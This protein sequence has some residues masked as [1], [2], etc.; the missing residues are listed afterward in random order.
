MMNIRRRRQAA[1]E[2]LLVAQRLE[3]AAVRQSLELIPSDIDPALWEA[4]IDVLRE[5]GAY[6]RRCGRH[7]LPGTAGRRQPPARGRRRKY[8][9]YP[10]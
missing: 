1:R 10:R 7:L 5:E 6:L 2:T 3:G 4:T 8:R 9:G